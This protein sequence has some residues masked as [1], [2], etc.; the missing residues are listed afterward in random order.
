MPNFDEV[1]RLAEE[2][3][4]KDAKSLDAKMILEK[5]LTLERIKQQVEDIAIPKVEKQE[6]FGKQIGEKKMEKFRIKKIYILIAVYIIL[7]VTE[8]FFY[9]PYHNIQII[10]TQQNVPYT[11]ITG[12]GYATMADITN[13][14]ANVDMKESQWKSSGNGKTVNTSQIYL[15]VSIT[16]ILA[17]GLYFLLQREEKKIIEDNLQMPELDIDGLA[18]AD[19]ETQKAEMEKY[20]Q[21][22]TEYIKKKG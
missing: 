14:N 16:T 12:S 11:V 3:A 21:K 18:F 8:L 17:T 22:L 9:V 13:D 2:Q 7:I 1:K 4:R 10:R 5:L 20:T 19:K 6:S 15:N